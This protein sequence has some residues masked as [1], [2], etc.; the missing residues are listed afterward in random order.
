MKHGVE[1]GT[2]RILPTKNNDSY[3]MEGMLVLDLVTS[4]TKE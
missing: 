3:Y 4:V 1:N 2:D